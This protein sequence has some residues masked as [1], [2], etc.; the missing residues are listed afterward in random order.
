MTNAPQLHM[1]VFNRP[2]E[3]VSDANDTVIGVV[4]LQDKHPI[5]FE[6]GKLSEA[7]LNCIVTKRSSL[8]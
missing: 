8:E 1:L 7:E 4:H 3:V 2:F 5:V 6:S